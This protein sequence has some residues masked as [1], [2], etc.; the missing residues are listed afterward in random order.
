VTQTRPAISVLLPTYNSATIIRPT[1]ESVKWVDEILV[2]DSFSN[3]NTLDICQ[4]Y[5]ARIIQHEYIQSA[6]QKN[7]AIP[8]C[9]YEWTFQIDHD[10]V[11][12]EGLEEEI[13]KAL[14]ECREEYDGFI[15]PFK[16]DILG[17]WVKVSGLYPEYHLR[18]FRR[19]VGRFEDKE[20]HAHVKVPGQVG[21]LNHH[22]IHYG[23]PNISKRLGNVDRYTRYQADELRKRGQKFRWWHLVLRP[24]AL[25]LYN[26]IYQQGFRAGYRGFLIAALEVTFD[27]WS[28][29][30]LWELE[31][32]GLESSPGS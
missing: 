29:A 17:Q 14:I 7:W 19:D 15:I 9:R 32:L 16:H 5:G 20:V 22:I 24:V 25:F 28:Y 30:K 10:E 13:E 18:L 4:E 3:D 1:L 21:V 27:F 26:Y 2:V 23:M 31:E 12:E 6:K 8:Q 11:L